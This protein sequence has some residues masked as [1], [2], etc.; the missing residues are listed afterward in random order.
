[1]NAWSR[2]AGGERPDT[3]FNKDYL[4]KWF[5]SQGGQDKSLIGK[6]YLSKVQKQERKYCA[7]VRSAACRG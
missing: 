4:R 3:K 6:L 2:I 5:M 1:M 7:N